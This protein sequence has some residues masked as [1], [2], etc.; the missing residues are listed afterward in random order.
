MRNGPTPVQETI[1]ALLE[2]LLNAG[3]ICK[4]AAD[5][6]LLLELYSLL[7]YLEPDEHDVAARL[8]QLRFVPTRIADL[9]LY[10]L[11]IPLPDVLV[12]LVPASTLPEAQALRR[13]LA[14]AGLPTRA[15]LEH[16]CAGLSMARPLVQ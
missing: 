3:V 10:L 14:T 11:Y 15:D 13:C 1:Q 9:G 6:E 5:G 16:L 4:T 12:Y 8:S 7:E 2:T